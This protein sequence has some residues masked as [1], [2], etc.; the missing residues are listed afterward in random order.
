MTEP[1]ELIKLI[2]GHMSK[3]A[4]LRYEEDYDAGIYLGMRSIRWLVYNF[5][6]APREEETPNDQQDFG[7]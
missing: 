7:L 5:F 2:D 1:E 4:D 3:Y 6:N